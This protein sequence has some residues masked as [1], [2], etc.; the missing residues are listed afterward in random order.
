MAAI[1][2][3]VALM[4]IFVFTLVASTATVTRDLIEQARSHTLYRRTR[5]SEA[6]AGRHSHAT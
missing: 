2:L 3:V 5:P 1:V 4:V 6:S